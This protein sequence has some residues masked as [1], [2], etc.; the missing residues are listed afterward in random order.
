MNHSH[1]Y[2]ITAE[3]CTYSDWW[4]TYGFIVPVNS[5]WYP[6]RWSHSWCLM[7]LKRGKGVAFLAETKPPPRY[8]STH[9]WENQ[10]V[11]CI[12]NDSYPKYRREGEKLIIK[13]SKKQLESKHVTCQC[14]VKA[15]WSPQN[16]IPG[17]QCLD[18]VKGISFWRNCGAACVGG[19][20][21]HENLAYQWSW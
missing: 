11:E 1:C 19:G 15:H 8:L 4:N 12:L 14:P 3:L 9:H 18:W 20:V 13:A 7:V 16:N 21:I 2:R 10:C 17:K 5:Y 6:I